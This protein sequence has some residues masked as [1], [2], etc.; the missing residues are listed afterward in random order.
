M[1][2]P[3]LPAGVDTP[4]PD[5]NLFREDGFESLERRPAALCVEVSGVDAGDRI[6]VEGIVRPVAGEKPGA[7][8]AEDG[9]RPP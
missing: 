7:G 5:D 8:Y 6:R 2:L 4:A 1:R 9:G 3:K